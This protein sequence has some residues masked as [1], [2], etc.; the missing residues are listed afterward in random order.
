MGTS[1]SNPNGVRPAYDTS[2][3]GRYWG[4][5]LPLCRGLQRATIL[6][7][8]SLLDWALGQLGRALFFPS[9]VPSF[10]KPQLAGLLVLAQGA[11]AGQAVL[12]D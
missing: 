3:A 12:A 2:L 7:I 8:V 1:S 4:R 11:G 5:G 10:R 9:G 6:I